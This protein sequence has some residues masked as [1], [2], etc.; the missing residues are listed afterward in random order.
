MSKKNKS[1]T[2]ALFA[3]AIASILW[4][5]NVPITKIGLQY[6]PINVFASVKLL[7][8]GIFLLFIIRRHWKPLPIKLVPTI[9]ISTL[10]GYVLNILFFYKGLSYTSGSSV[11]V[12]F[13]L[14][15][16]ILYFLSIE[17]LKE[18]FS[19]KILFGSLIAFGGTIIIVVLPMLGTSL[20]TSVIGN[21]LILLAVLSDAIGTIMIKPVLRYVKPLQIV[22]IRTLIAG[23]IFFFLNS[24]SVISFDY[25][26]VPTSGHIALFYGVV[27]ALIIAQWLTS[28][29]LKRLSVEESS[30]LAYISPV[31]GVVSS[32]IL[33]DEKLSALFVAGAGLI[34]WG[35]YVAETRSS[36]LWP[37][38]KRPQR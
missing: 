13:T 17:F 35:V 34:F 14:G 20:N 27:M 12:I 4:G 15:P 36:Q 18:K 33:L 28:Y 11:S 26:T 31:F 8:A 30:V 22:T 3:M 6:F 21:I 37:M 24:R 16:L 19:A 29:G 9:V 7:L 10:V 23:V 32:V 5:V 1:R 25:G 2:V 38:F